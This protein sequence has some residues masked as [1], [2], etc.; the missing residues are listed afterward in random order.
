MGITLKGNF[1][2]GGGIRERISALHGN[3]TLLSDIGLLPHGS[4]MAVVF[5]VVN[6]AYYLQE[7]VKFLL[8]VNKIE[9][10][11]VFAVF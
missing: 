10:L 6:T 1:S 7:K 2:V 4:L 9:A 5:L 8:V 11:A 3:V